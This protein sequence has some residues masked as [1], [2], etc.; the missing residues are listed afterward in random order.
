VSPKSI[1]RIRVQILGLVQGVGFRP[2]VYRLANDLGLAGWVNNSPEGVTIEA[3]G[4][5]LSLDTFLTRLSAERPPLSVLQSL[6]VVHLDPAP[7]RTFEI[8]ESEAR[9][10][11][12][13]LLMPDIATCDACIKEISDKTYRR[14]LYPFTNC[15]NCGPRF[16]IVA[17]LPYDRPLTTMAGFP[18]CADCRAEYEN[19]ADRRFHAQPIA[20]PACGPKV[21]LWDRQGR[22][23]AR[24]DAAL[25]QAEEAIREGK[26][27]AL[28]GLGGFQLVCDA[29][30]AQA[31]GE[32]RRRKRREEKPFA[33]LAPSL[34]AVRALCE[35]SAVEERLLRSPA[36]PIVLLRRKPDAAVA[37]AVAPG[38]PSLG[39]MLPYT[40]LHH[41]LLADLGF[42]VVATSGNLCEEPIVTDEREAVRRLSGLADLF[43]VHDRPIARHVDDSI[44]RVIAGRE[45]VLRRAR[46]YAPLPILLKADVP[47]TLAVGA[48]LKNTLAFTSG[49]RV[50]LSQHI[51]DLENEEA[52]VAFRRAV[53]D[54]PRIYGLTF[55]RVAA[56]LHPDYVSTR[57]ADRSGL[58]KFGVQH[59]V[60]HVLACLVENEVDGPALGVAWDGVGLGTDGSI[61]GGEFFRVEEGDARRVAH[62]RSFPLPGGE[63][64][65][66]EPRR[67]ALGLAFEAFGPSARLPAGLFS[68]EE[69]RVLLAALERGT[70]VLWTTS[71]GRLFDAVASLAGLC[72]RSAFEGQAAMRLEFAADGA[73]PDE[74]AEAYPLPLLRRDGV[75]V[76]DWEPML[77]ELRSDLDSGSP[78]GRVSSRF[79][80]ALAEAITAVARE[81]GLPCVA[82]SGGCFQ[83]RR[84][85]EETV[86]RL[87][88]AGFRPYLHQRVPPNDGGIALGQAVAPLYL[89]A[90]P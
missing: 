74:P 89:K 65:I 27:V 44:V 30:N 23:L 70:S 10:E 56:D 79:H 45:T 4:G 60:A 48:H 84:L 72:Q 12:R 52:L 35:V 58:P 75:L 55:D 2:F 11:R 63:A 42:P 78:V 90:R 69:L 66:R 83:N 47:P 36:A 17:G 19:P 43:L 82:L 34:D 6:E 59:H 28:K 53:A 81:Q 37:D 62:L 31:V 32:L 73:E 8:R 71:A 51:G 3:Q 85:T 38:N 26:I 46:G 57:Q 88:A 14:Y 76:L 7:Y 87:E 86:R 33:L 50:F 49:R 41:L 18:M 9:G 13:A 20:C 24:E 5:R 25:R 68:E 61:W 29:R 54:L 21:Y 67:S 16:S 80:D 22:E 15:T 40:P 39:V 77:R 64:A 1:E